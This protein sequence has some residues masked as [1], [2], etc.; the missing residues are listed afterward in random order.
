MGNSSSTDLEFICKTAIES[1][2]NKQK[3]VIIH[4]NV[5]I[6]LGKPMETPENVMAYMQRFGYIVHCEINEN[7]YVLSL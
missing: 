4:P 7:K 3:I 5:S 6:L 1:F 2:R